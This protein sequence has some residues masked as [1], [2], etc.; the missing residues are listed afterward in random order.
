MSIL[1]EQT[2]FFGPAHFPLRTYIDRRRPDE[3]CSHTDAQDRRGST[4]QQ[5]KKTTHE[6][7]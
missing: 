2:R 7:L 5:L 1:I 4:A 3:R 6:A